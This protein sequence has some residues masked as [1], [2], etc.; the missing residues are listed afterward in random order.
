MVKNENKLKFGTN[1][2]NKLLFPSKMGVGLMKLG[3]KRLKFRFNF[4]FI[5]KFNIHYKLILFFLLI[6]L[7][8]LSFS[9]GVTYLFAKSAI[10]NK[11]KD[12]SK[13]SLAQ[14]GVNIEVKLKNYEDIS[15]QLIANSEINNIVDSMVNSPHF[16]ERYNMK[17]L[18]T[19]YLAGFKY[20]D[21]Y[22]F[23][24]VF[25]DPSQKVVYNLSD[26]VPQSFI[27]THA[28]QEYAQELDR[29]E[30][31]WSSLLPVPNI[32]QEMVNNVIFGRKITKS[33]TN[34]NL[35]SFFIFLREESLDQLLNHELYRE[36]NNQ[37]LN[38]KK[39]KYSMLLSEEGQVISAPFKE[40][41]GAEI[42]TLI[43]NAQPLPLQKQKDEL[44]SSLEETRVLFT[45]QPLEHNW[46]LLNV[47]P[48]SYLFKE[49]GWLRWITL[50]LLILAGL[51]AF[52]LSWRLSKMIS[53][54]IIQ[55]VDAMKQT[56]EGDLKPRTN[57]NSEDELGYL[58]KAFNKMMDKF[59]ALIIETKKAVEQ[60][61]QLGE[62]MNQSAEEL[63]QTSEGVATA[64]EQITRGTTEQSSEIEKTS[65]EIFHL[66]EG[67]DQMLQRTGEIEGIAL[68][69]KKLSLDSQGA[70]NQLLRKAKETGEITDLVYE[71][72][73]ELTSEANEIGKITET[74]T[75]FAEQANL[76]AINTAI[77]AARVGEAGRGFSVLAGEIDNLG[78]QSKKAAA[79][80]NRIL[81]RIQEKTLNSAEYVGQAHQIVDEHFAAVTIVNDSFSEI[82]NAMDKT[83]T[84]INQ[85]ALDLTRVNLLK[86][87]SVNSMLT[88]NSISGETASAAEEVSGAAEE[89]ASTATHLQ[90][91]A[92]NLKLMAERLEAAIKVFKV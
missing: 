21:E 90:Q 7:I 12:Y 86:E 42:T 82:I 52:I 29:H 3:R 91:L 57:V 92:F 71:N 78:T 89:Q 6:A 43:N 16:F 44:Y 45:F 73:S 37:L 39:N 50:A 46:Y 75:S 26:R 30:F 79:T 28:F 60:V 2:N 40:Y 27:N 47:F 38:K 85:A 80:I 62:L 23:D 56:E 9:G 5:Q 13:E 72:I 22:I 69:T 20:G 65:S 48:V 88:I 31:A 36:K 49:I 25:L 14:K 66:A 34:E 35:G 10:I 87:S 74:I 59:S 76:L 61:V 55:V 83:V 4:H 63:T 68:T 84:M 1:N 15:F 67:I 33:G 54:P 8:P 53:I 58:G 51:F 17:N 18:F 19:Q 70:M 24:M 64:M 41:V 81:S 11:I 32:N 77:E